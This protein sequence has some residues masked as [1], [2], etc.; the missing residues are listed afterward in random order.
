MVPLPHHFSK[1][2][3]RSLE[4]YPLQEVRKYPVTPAQS[5]KLVSVEITW[6]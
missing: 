2:Q 3:V 1:D 5:H 4:S 6:Q